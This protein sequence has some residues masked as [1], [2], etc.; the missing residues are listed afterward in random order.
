MNM[1][2]SA[3]LKNLERIIISLGFVERRIKIMS[4]EV[5]EPNQTIICPGASNDL[6]LISDDV[7]YYIADPKSKADF[8]RTPW[9]MKLKK[10][11]M[12]KDLSTSNAKERISSLLTLLRQKMG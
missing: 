9:F 7:Y 2:N 10:N 12:I 3:L 5:L 11:E 8:S 4:D 1:S 6:D